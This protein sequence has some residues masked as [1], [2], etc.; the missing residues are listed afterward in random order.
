M[1]LLSACTD[2]PTPTPPPEVVTPTPGPNI[3]HQ[4][5]ESRYIETD[6]TLVFANTYLYIGTEHQNGTDLIAY[7]FHYEGPLILDGFEVPEGKAM[8]MIGSYLWE[9]QIDVSAEY[10][11]HILRATL[12]INPE[13]SYMEG[14]LTIDGEAYQQYMGFVHTTYIPITDDE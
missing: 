5:W 3:D 2:E 8:P 9:R 10:Y 12:Q 11:G 6:E 7:I 1:L 14:W 13:A 4:T